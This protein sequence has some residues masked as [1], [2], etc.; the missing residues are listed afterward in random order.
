MILKK[1]IKIFKVTRSKVWG[2]DNLFGKGIPVDGSLSNVCLSNSNIR[3]KGH[4]KCTYV[5]QYYYNDGAHW[6][7]VEEDQQRCIQP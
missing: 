1:T 4:L 7:A 2:K 6:S 3:E 5:I